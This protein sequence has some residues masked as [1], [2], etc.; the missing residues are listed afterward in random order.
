MTYLQG[1]LLAVFALGA[2][3]ALF[4]T[5]RKRWA[6]EQRAKEQAALAAVGRNVDELAHD[7][8]NLIGLI[9]LNL[10]MAPMVDEEDR[11]E[12]LADL[13]HSAEMVY[14]MF[15]RI[16][17]RSEDLEGASPEQL[18]QTLT[19]MVRRTGVEVTLDI[20]AP[21]R[22][23]GS[24]LAFLRLAENLLMNAAR[25][26]TLAGVPRLRVRMTEASL[27]VENPIRSATSLDDSIYE[28]GVSRSGSTGRGLAIA[29]AAADALGCALTHHVEGRMV[30]FVV[31]PALDAHAQ[32]VGA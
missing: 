15:R 24:P 6:A 4:W 2:G 17:G 5:W 27:E 23:E 21:L 32:R 3:S 8:S 12:V 11:D 13:G 29:K 30:T 26:A 10:R 9:H 14:A 7:L 18:L 28:S 25:E 31:R 16:R 20:E 19:H 1:A 22:A